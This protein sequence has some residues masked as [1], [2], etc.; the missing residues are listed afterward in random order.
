M[1]IL[2]DWGEK[3][4]RCDWLRGDVCILDFYIVF[5][6]NMREF[7]TRNLKSKG[8]RETFFIKMQHENVA[9]CLIQIKNDL[10]EKT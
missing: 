7:K 9:F 4:D 2:Y 10:E 5:N 3:Y 6:Y 8:S 1:L